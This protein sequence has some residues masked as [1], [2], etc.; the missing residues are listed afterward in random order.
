MVG[1][2]GQE[3]ITN[4]VIEEENSLEGSYYS[5]GEHAQKEGES[6]KGYDEFVNDNSLID[7]YMSV[8][9]DK[10]STQEEVEQAIRNIHSLSID[11]QV[12]Y[13]EKEGLMNNSTKSFKENVQLNPDERTEDEITVANDVKNQFNKDFGLSVENVKVISELVDRLDAGEEIKIDEVKEDLAGNYSIS[14]ESCKEVV[15]ESIF[16]K[17]KNSVSKFFNGI[18]NEQTRDYENEK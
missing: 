11:M 3:A 10:N 9:Q 2:E 15:K 16:S 17:I 13:F 14:G 1:Q 7:E 6:I 4:N 18:T 8:L 5:S 12:M